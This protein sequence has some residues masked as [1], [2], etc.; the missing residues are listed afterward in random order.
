MT[1]FTGDTMKA[2]YGGEY[3]GAYDTGDRI[4][5]GAFGMVALSRR[6]CDGLEV[7]DYFHHLNIE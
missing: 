2:D 5:E 6:K 7:T 3:S 4:G 1:H